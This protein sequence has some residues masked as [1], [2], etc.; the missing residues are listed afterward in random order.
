MRELISNA[1]D[2]ADKLRFEALQNPNLLE[3]DLELK[4]CVEV[5][6]EAKTITVREIGIG[7]SRKE[8][9]ENLGTITKSGTKEFLNLLTDNEAKDTK[10]NRQLGFMYLLLW[11]IK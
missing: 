6:I 9:I 7:M 5:D 1:L 10:L 2:A 11:P 3:N 4:V 8:V